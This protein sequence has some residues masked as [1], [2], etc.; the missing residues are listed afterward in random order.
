MSATEAYVD[1]QIG[2][3]QGALDQVFLLLCTFLIIYMQA[4]FAFLEAGSVRSKNVRSILIKNLLDAANGAIW[5]YF[6]GYG[7]Y[8]CSGGDEGGPTTSDMYLVSDQSAF[9]DWIMSYAFAVTTCTIVS[10]AVASRYTID[11]Y[12][13]F[14]SLMVAWVYPMAAYWCWKGWLAADGY[15]DFAG[16]GAVHMIGGWAGI[17]GCKF[18]G[19]RYGR[20]S[21]E[22][23]KFVD[24]GLRASSVTFQI[25]G[26]F[27]LIFGWYGF[28]AGSAAGATPTQM[29]LAARA[30]INTTLAAATGGMSALFYSHFAYHRHDIEFIVNSILGALVAITA[31]CGF[32]ETWAA[33]L[34]GIFGMFMYTFAAWSTVYLLKADDPLNAFAVHGCCGMLGVIVTGLFA[35]EKPVADYG[36]SYY[37]CLMG[38]GGDLIAAQLSAVCVLG[39]WSA[40][41][42]FVV[43]GLANILCP[44]TRLDKD[45]E[46]LGMDIKYID[47]YLHQNQMTPQMVK[48]FNE[49]K[50]AMQRKMKTKPIAGSTKGGSKDA[51]KAGSSA[52]ASAKKE[53][54]V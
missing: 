9:T 52:G 21:T 37:G 11:L 49:K 25:L 34:I 51:T 40:G 3:I 6:I 24:N 38:G 8:G 1:E 28:N 43:F 14:V 46:I 32:V 47:G 17:V 39:T 26:G 53:N 36:A 15:L 30:A 27:I 5:W 13:F 2:I 7:I 50:I 20:F 18:A 45:D 48:E 54:A 41:H 44:G 4:G 33:L 19:P 10:G 29:G 42:A 12:L 31:G 35:A 23:G 16:S 22:G